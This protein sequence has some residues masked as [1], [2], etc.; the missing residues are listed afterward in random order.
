MSE[1][2]NEKSKIS[3]TRLIFLAIVDKTAAFVA[4][5]GPEFQEKIRQNEINNP[6][7]NFL[8]DNDPYHAYYKHKVKEIEENKGSSDTTSQQQQSQMPQIQK[9]SLTGVKTQEQQKI[10]E[11][12]FIPKEPP[13]DFEF[14]TDAP[15]ISPLDIDVIKLTAQFVSRNGR[16]FLTNL[17]NK[18]HRNALFDFL[19][20]QHSHFSYFTRLVEHYTKILLPPKDLA[21]KLRKESDNIFHIFKDV[22]YRSEWQKFQ[23]RE[24]A[25]EDELIEK[26]RVAYAQIDWHDFVVV[27][28]VDYQPNEIG[29]FPPPTTPQDVG[30]RVVA[31]ERLELLGSN[32]NIDSATMIERIIEDETRVSDDD[33]S[34][35]YGP[36]RKMNEIS[37]APP[38]E[39]NRQADKNIDEV[40]M[41]EDSDED[42][43][44][45]ATS[46]MKRP[47]SNMNAPAPPPGI[48][49]MPRSDLPLPPNPEKVIIR[50]DYDPRAKF[51]SSKIGGEEYFTSPIT[52]ERIPASSIPEHMRISLLDP[53]WIDQKEKEKKEREE[54]EEV[55]APGASIES[56]LK[57]M[58]EFRRDIF[59]RGVDETTIGK[60]IGEE[61]KRREEKPIWDGHTATMEKTTKRA[62]T[63][64][65]V[66]DQIK[67]IH[68]TQG[69]VEDDSQK[70]GP[71]IVPRQQQSQ[72]KFTTYGYQLPTLRPVDSTS[73]LLRPLTTPNPAVVMIP[74]QTQATIMRPPQPPMIIPAPQPVVELPPPTT[75]LDFMDEPA[76]KRAKTEEQLVPEEEY[77]ARFGGPNALVS[78]NLQVPYIPDKGEWNLNGQMIT[79]TL[80]LGDPVSVIKTKLSEILGMPIAKQKL[81]YEVSEAFY[82][83]SNP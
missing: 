31:Q 62:M 71:S 69:L 36:T 79:F 15:S 66:E 73:I 8:N 22:Q 74:Q 9:L 11:Q 53:K 23:L 47:A 54:Q 18:E 58:A 82:I 50:K 29:N 19:K 41:D 48:L 65:T 55:L 24:K 27:E 28:T 4:R 2:T 45:P 38:V 56:Q 35:L 68:Q 30:A 13:S 25:R 43:P 40:A 64:I 63:G 57:T 3:K 1:V 72:Q 49:P 5:N 42:E 34:R 61:D 77:I 10:I 21:E 44:R 26:E 39:D 32:L 76:H 7:F 59:G 33:Y 37:L 12:M 78:F 16:P 6:K 17:M 67:Q 60:R 83:F 81:Q 52:G 80:K 75:S 14:I 20:P 51:Q 70:I 46:Q